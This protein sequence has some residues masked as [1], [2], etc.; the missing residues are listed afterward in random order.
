M[1]GKLLEPLVQALDIPI[2]AVRGLGA[3]L[4]NL[5][6]D[7]VES[8][9]VDVGVKV[10]AVQDLVALFV[11]DLALL[12][13]DVV[14]VKDVLTHREVDFLDLALGAL[15][16]LAHDLVLDGHVIGHVVLGHHGRDLVHAVAAKQAHEVVLKRQVEL[17]LARVALTARTAAELVVNTT[18]LVTLGTND[19]QAAGGKH[20]VVLDRAHLL[21]AGHGL[22]ALLA[23]GLL[24][25][26]AVLAQ[27]VQRDKLGVAAQQDVGT[28]TGHVGC[29]GNGALAAGLRDDLCLALVELGV[30]HVVLDAALIQNAREL[31]G[32]LDR[33]GAHQARL[34][35]GVALA[36]V[37]GHGLELGVHGAIDQVVVVLADNRLVGR[38]DLHGNVIDLAELGV[39]GH[40]GTGHARELVVHQEVVLQGDGR[41]GLVLFF[42][43]HAFL[44]LNCLVQAL[45][46]TPALHDT[47]GELV[48]DLD[49]AVGDHVLLVA[50]E[51]VLGL[52]GLLQVVDQLARLVGIDVLDAK[53]PLDLLKAFLGRGDGVL[54]LV[55]LKVDLGD[56]TANGAGKVLVGA[57]R[58][59]AGAR[60]DKRGPGLIDQ[61]GV[62]LVDD[63][64]VVPTLNA[65]VRTGHHVVAQVVEAKLRVGAIGD[66]GRIGG[67]LHADL[68]AVLQKTNLHAQEAVDLAHPLGVALGQVVVDRDN[69]HALARN[70]V[71]I[72]CQGRDKR[73]ALAGLHLGDGAAV[74]RDGANDLHV[75]VAQPGR[76][77][78]SLTHRRKGVGEKIV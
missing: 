57:G 12:V 52:Q 3:E 63:G 48:D 69:V 13:H 30:K 67:L 73:L 66:V 50:V 15:N 6:L 11:D 24:K 59:G 76:A 43:N 55:H 35:L 74:K 27:Q 46:V 16:G 5:A 44:G 2:L 56:K 62:G 25:V 42:D 39:L 75:K 41:Q 31:L 28:T 72:T 70:G 78:R 77:L 64:K 40:S 45:G 68:H 9:L 65:L 32:V 14:V 23:R 1:T 26:N 71:E 33:D 10:L 20:V 18:A 47:T 21:G 49:L 54:G 19:A 7:G 51:H 36:N 38:N 60:D 4:G 34:A 22:D 61:D 17:G 58:L 29:D 8:D 37:I 53:A